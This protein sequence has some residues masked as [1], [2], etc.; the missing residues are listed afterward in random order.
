MTKIVIFGKSN[1]KVRVIALL[2]CS[3][4]V[5][6]TISKLATRMHTQSQRPMSIRPIKNPLYD[7]IYGQ[8][9]HFL[10]LVSRKEKRRQ[11]E[12]FVADVGIVPRDVLRRGCFN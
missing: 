6:Q 1:K 10:N 8:S 11:S 9:R 7:R 4:I 12:D 3:S 5:I 2:S